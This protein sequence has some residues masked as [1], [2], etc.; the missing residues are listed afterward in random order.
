MNDAACHRFD[1]KTLLATGAARGIGR[2]VAARLVAEGAHVVLADIDGD[3]AENAAAAINGARG[4]AGRAEPAALDVTDEA[5]TRSLIDQ[6]AATRGRL[7][8]LFANAAILDISPL[9]T[10]R[11]NR[12]RE[13]VTVNM[14]SVLISA[15]AAAPLIARSGGGAILATASIMGQVGSV[16]S[17]PYST[18]KGGVIN[19]VRCLA[20]ELA[21]QGIVVNGL[22]PG[23]I[24]TRMAR[25]ADGGH[26]HET[27][28]F[29]DVYL[30]YGKI[31]MRRP[32]QPEDLA[33]PAAFLLSS[34]AAYVTGQI[35][36]VDGG[37]TAIF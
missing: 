27:A 16:E 14:E 34:D 13:V 10:L 3:T 29:R 9:E 22:A 18:A 36:T 33:G 11:L 15:L 1:G 7:D 12:F 31:P 37:V 30:K 21:G 24:D 19:M 26:E 32:G 17:I 4:A 35:L 8:G 20:C 28:Y 5:A 6:I 23:F 2:A 25:L